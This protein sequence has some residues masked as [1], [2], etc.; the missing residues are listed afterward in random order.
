MKTQPTQA[1]A[2]EAAW[3]VLENACVPQG[4][5]AS[6][7][8]T[9][10]YRKIWAR[11]SMMAGIT[12]FFAGNEV[13]RE[14]LKN[15][16]LY[17]ARFQAEDGQIPS[18]VGLEENPHV[19]FGSLAGRID[20]TL[21]WLIGASICADEWEEQK[22]N[23]FPHVEKAIRLL[24]SWEMNHRGL[25][26]TPLGGNW[27]DEYL[28]QGYTLYDNVLRVWALRL[29]GRIW[30]RNDWKTDAERIGQLLKINF[31]P[32]QAE[33][34]SLYHA[35]AYRKANKETTAWMWFSL[36]PQGYD[37]RW[38]MAGNALALCL[39]LHPEPEKLHHYLLNWMNQKGHAM[40][41]VFYPVVQ[42]GDADW[43]LLEKNYSYRFKN[44]P[45]HFHNGGAWPI[46]LGWLGL[47]FAIGGQTEAGNRMQQS[48]LE[49]LE[50]EEPAF[51]FHEYWTSHTLQPGGVAPLCFTAAG[52]ILLDL[53][54][55]KTDALKNWFV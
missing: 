28:V 3:E 37:T 7:L 10:N 45:H 11:D 17:L 46:F 41:P 35:E 50:K 1:W 21:W 13:L 23:L 49:C 18:N 24:H 20:A 42:P 48:V 14:G 22:P 2:R 15:A 52:T 30:N 47:G 12:G 6:T 25:L 53:A 31:Y 9:D 39:G 38:D 40:L 36:G 8:E 29:A 19:S 33:S 26:Y 44:H 55:Q 4:I 16:V 32:G 43:A 34:D 5:L 27:A 54:Q 51:S